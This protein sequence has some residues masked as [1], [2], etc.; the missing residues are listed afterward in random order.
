M[1][2]SGRKTPPKLVE[3]ISE[4]YNV[5]LSEAFEILVKVKENN[6]GVLKGLKLRKFFHLVRSIITDKNLKTQQ[7]I[8]ARKQKMEEN[9]PL[10]L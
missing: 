7:E 10:L 4:R 5:S 1:E 2:K 6:G 8:K 9:L 3:I